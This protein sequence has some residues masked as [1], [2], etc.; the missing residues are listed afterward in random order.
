MELQILRRSTGLKGTWKDPEFASC[1]SVVTKGARVV[2]FSCVCCLKEAQDLYKSPLKSD[3]SECQM[4]PWIPECCVFLVFFK[5][6]CN[7]DSYTLFFMCGAETKIQN[8]KSDIFFQRNKKNYTELLWIWIDLVSL[9]LLMKSPQADYFTLHLDPIK[10]HCRVTW[11][12]SKMACKF[13]FV[14]VYSVSLL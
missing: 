10:S 1:T 7:I 13:L 8:L 4:K 9:Q 14:T 6:K 11:K 5:Q 12:Y 2:F 3:F